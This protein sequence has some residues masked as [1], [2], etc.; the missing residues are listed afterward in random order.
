MRACWFY[1][2]FYVN[3]QFLGML[4]DLDES[5]V[6]RHLQRFEPM[7]ADD[8]NINKKWEAI[9]FEL[10]T[11]KYYRNFDSKKQERKTSQYENNNLRK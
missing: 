1:Y 5:N 10:E 11:I 6:C 4:F 9:K 7:L 2:R 3:F 8:T